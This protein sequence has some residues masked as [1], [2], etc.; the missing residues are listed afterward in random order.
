MLSFVVF[1]EKVYILQIK[2]SGLTFSQLH[3]IIVLHL[4]YFCCCFGQDFSITQE[5]GWT[6]YKVCGTKKIQKP[7]FT[8]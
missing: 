5:Q 1:E 4:C 8:D 7:G 2:S 6:T 3:S